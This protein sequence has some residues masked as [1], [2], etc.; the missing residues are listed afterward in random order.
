[1]NRCAIIFSLLPLSNVLKDPGKNLGAHAGILAA[2][3][4]L[5]TVGKIGTMPNMAELSGFIIVPQG[6]EGETEEEAQAAERAS[7][8]LTDVGGD[9]NDLSGSM[10]PL[11]QNRPLENLTFLSRGRRFASGTNTN[12]EEA[13]VGLLMFL[14]GSRPCFVVHASATLLSVYRLTSFIITCI[15]F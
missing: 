2:L 9:S 11:F 3:V 4:I 14:I 8:D 1:L 5:E 13:E 7:R 12:Y 15:C 6:R 10:L